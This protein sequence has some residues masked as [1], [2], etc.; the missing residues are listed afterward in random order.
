MAENLDAAR[1]ALAAELDH[2]RK[3]AEYY[4]SRVEAL[5]LALAKLD[6]VESADFG[7][8]GRAS[9][10]GGTAKQKAAALAG[11][12]AKAA[13]GGGRK[14]V[15]RPAAK[16][17]AKKVATK[18]AKVDLPSTRQDFWLNL[19]GPEPKT[20][21]EITQ[22]AIAA[23]GIKENE[24][25]KMTVIRNRVAPS[26]AGLLKNRMIQDAGTGRERT[27]MRTTQ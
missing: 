13:R 9:F 4:A 19:V 12:P 23:L 2:A 18:K 11:K 16:A 22:A 10:N 25:D 6:E 24:A 15:A 14:T 1:T 27:Y 20:A 7:G 21:A 8:T 3:G 5:T 26:L 17:A